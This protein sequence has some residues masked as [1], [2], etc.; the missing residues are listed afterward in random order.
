MLPQ[1]SVFNLVNLALK[2]PN[3]QLLATQGYVSANYN[4]D[5]Y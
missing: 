1:K 3:L 2:S 5:L 4:L